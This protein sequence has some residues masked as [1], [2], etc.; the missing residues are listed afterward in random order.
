MTTTSSPKNDILSPK[1]ISSIKD[2]ADNVGLSR[3]A[4]IV[5]NQVSSPYNDI[6]SPKN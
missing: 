3:I 1:D 4:S 6:N 5:L 2:N